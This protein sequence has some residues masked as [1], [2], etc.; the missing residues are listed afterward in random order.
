MGEVELVIAWTIQTVANVIVVRIGRRARLGGVNNVQ[1]WTAILAVLQEDDGKLE[2]RQPMHGNRIE[3]CLVYIRWASQ[4]LGRRE[5][6]LKLLQAS[7]GK[8]QHQLLP[9]G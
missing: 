6:R 3:G 9:F 5:I 8:A 2:G 4:R 1:F 7:T